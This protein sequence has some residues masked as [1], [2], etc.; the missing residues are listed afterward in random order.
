MNKKIDFKKYSITLLGIIIVV[1]NA[2]TPKPEPIR[3]GYDLCMYCKMMISDRRYGGE[4]VTRK[5]KIYKF[6]S[7]ECL[8]GWCLT[9]TTKPDDIYSLW[10]VEFDHPEI[11]INAYQA[12]YLQS[13]DLRSPMGLNFTA[14]SDSSM[15][16]KVEQLYIGSLLDWVEVQKEVKNQWLSDGK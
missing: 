8:S 2:C 14:F 16:K 6:D 11:L 13:K 4:L 10:V 3:F 1:L 12:V 7:A 9:E 5:G 15:A